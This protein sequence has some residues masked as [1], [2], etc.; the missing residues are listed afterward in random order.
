MDQSWLLSWV[1]RG[2][3]WLQVNCNNRCFCWWSIYSCRESSDDTRADLD[4]YGSSLQAIFHLEVVAF[5]PTFYDMGNTCNESQA[6]SDVLL[7]VTVITTCQKLFTG[8][9]NLWLSF[10]A[11]PHTKPT[12]VFKC[13][14]SNPKL[15]TIFQT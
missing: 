11:T 9:V 13:S 2:S 12:N 10:S 8:E 5:Q 7:T 15:V 4:E 14:A 6:G 3:Y 1:F